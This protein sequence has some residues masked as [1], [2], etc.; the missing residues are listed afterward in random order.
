MSVPLSPRDAA[1]LAL[2][3]V[4]E[5]G[6]NKAE[7]AR[8]LGVPRSSLYDHLDRATKLG[9]TPTTQAPDT[10][11][12]VA[13]TELKYKDK[14]RNL[15]AQIRELSRTNLSDEQVREFV[16]GL[17]KQ[18]PSYKEWDLTPYLTEDPSG[19][20]IPTLQ[21][22][23][24]HI[25]EVVDPNTINGVN[26][27]DLEIADKR[28]ERLLNKLLILC[29]VVK[30]E[31]GIVVILGGDMVSGFIHD[32]LTETNQGYTMEHVFWLF[33]RLSSLLKVLIYE[34]DK[35]FVSCVYGNHGRT[36]L[37]PRMK[38]A[39]HQNFDWLLYNM[40]ERHFASLYEGEESPIQ[41][42]IPTGFDALYRIY[43][44]TYLNTHGDRL[45]SGGGNGIIGMLGPV[46]RG[47]L[48]I[49]AQYATLG[50]T[51]DWVAM[52]HWHQR[53]HIDTHGIIVNGSLKGFDEFAQSALRAEP[54]P[55]SQN[56]WFTHPNYG[57]TYDCGIWLTD[58]SENRLQKE[59]ITWKD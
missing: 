19:P 59:W 44:T 46:I 33:D 4:I 23:D 10:A 50:Q 37:R 38:S 34:F 11:A 47:S 7:A 51:V 45:G 16:F 41:F 18:D 48:K 12:A 20:G 36:T 31:D 53:A 24:W 57:I 32:E 42:Q 2:D 9:L 52:G 21:L 28:I 30:A 17:S 43:D 40:L 29:N 54:Q 1:Q 27:F 8:Q 39:A 26:E 35:V 55:P 49:K 14:I 15:E 58:P 6:G 13:Q 5:C 25:G 56:L 22:S 3:M